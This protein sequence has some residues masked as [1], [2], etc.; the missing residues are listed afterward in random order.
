MEDANNIV[1]RLNYK[2]RRINM[3]NETFKDE[4]GTFHY[5]PVVWGDWKVG[6][7]IIFEGY[8]TVD[9]AATGGYEYTVGD[10]Y[11]VVEDGVCDVG[12]IDNN[13]IWACPECFSSAF[14]F[15][16][17]A[18]DA[19]LHAEDKYK[20]LKSKNQNQYADNH[21]MLAL[22]LSDYKTKLQEEKDQ[23]KQEKSLDNL[24]KELHNLKQEQKAISN[25][26]DDILN[27]INDVMKENGRSVVLT[28]KFNPHEYI[29]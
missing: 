25:K 13:G 14:K 8:N 15:S 9:E 23:P 7:E 22:W 12:P 26:I 27:E 28:E 17:K 2:E 29:A 4:K 5:E 16:R 19:I 1:Q 10:T 18:Y 6:D 21:K 11:L 24:L 20:E 3:N